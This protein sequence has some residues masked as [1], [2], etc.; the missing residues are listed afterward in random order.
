MVD[1]LLNSDQLDVR[2]TGAGVNLENNGWL[3]IQSG[4]STT[5]TNFRDM[6]QN[7][8]SEIGLDLPVIDQHFAKFFNFIKKCK[9]IRFC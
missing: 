5:L 3:I 4:A 7:A 8:F 1:H 6:D 2:H 9:K